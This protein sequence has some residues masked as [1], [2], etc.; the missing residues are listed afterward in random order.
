MATF[1]RAANGI[2]WL[3]ITWR[4]LATYSGNFEPICDECLES[5]IDCDDVVL[6][7]ILNEAFCPECGKKVISQ[8]KS[9]PED[10]HI[11]KLRE[12]FWLK[13]FGLSEDKP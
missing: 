5:L 6:I 4:E 2:A 12:Q 10:R 3:K 8:L 7:P 1:N 13:Y 11:E 9:Y